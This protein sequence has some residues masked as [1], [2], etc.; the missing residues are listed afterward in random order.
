MA[1]PSGG[2]LFRLLLT[3]VYRNIINERRDFPRRNDFNPTEKQ[4][5]ELPTCLDS[6]ADSS[7]AISHDHSPG[8]PLLLHLNNLTTKCPGNTPNTGSLPPRQPPK[9]FNTHI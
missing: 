5:N 1:R 3:I 4:P 6:K 7:S 2:D 8:P 9:K